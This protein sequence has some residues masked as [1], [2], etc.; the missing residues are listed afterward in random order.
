MTKDKDKTQKNISSDRV[1]GGI[2][3]EGSFSLEIFYEVSHMGLI[4]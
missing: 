4:E 3:E 1:S 2:N